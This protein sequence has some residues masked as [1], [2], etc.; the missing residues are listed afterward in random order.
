M[1]LFDLFFTSGG[2]FTQRRDLLGGWFVKY[3]MPRLI[4]HSERIV[5]R[6]RHPKSEI[7]TSPC[8]PTK[9]WRLVELFGDGLASR[10]ANINRTSRVMLAKARKGTHA[11]NL[12]NCQSGGKLTLNNLPLIIKTA[13][14]RNRYQHNPVNIC[15]RKHG[16]PMCSGSPL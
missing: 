10:R 11:N 3:P 9:R 13:K 8:Q 16:L 6:I 5:S 1:V 7:L 12:L 4:N 14:S 2:L 15:C